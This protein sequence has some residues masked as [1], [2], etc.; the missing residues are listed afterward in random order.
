MGRGEEGAK[1]PAHLKQQPAVRRRVHP[2]DTNRVR[3]VVVDG[4]AVADAVLDDA[5]LR[6]DVVADVR[7]EDVLE[8]WGRG[9]ECGCGYARGTRR[10][11]AGQAW[12]WGS[13]WGAVQM[14]EALL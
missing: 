14:W 7:G 13:L 9:M 12:K 3:R 11:E 6:R 1:P 5:G 10:R 4:P 8:L 2:V